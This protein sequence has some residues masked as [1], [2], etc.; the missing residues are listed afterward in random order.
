MYLT[1]KLQNL[2]IYGSLRGEA[3]SLWEVG[4]GD[5]L[6]VSPLTKIYEY[7]C[8][9]ISKIVLTWPCAYWDPRNHLATRLKGFRSQLE[10]GTRLMSP[11]VDVCWAKARLC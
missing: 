10:K 6:G 7:S 4:S 9:K 8:L 2:L 11:Q 5:N 1:R 3:L